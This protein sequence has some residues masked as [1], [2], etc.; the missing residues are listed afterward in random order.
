MR[1]NIVE[2]EEI[3]I[4]GIEVDLDFDWDEFFEAPDPILSEI[5]HVMKHNVYYFFSSGEKYIFG[6]RVSSIANIP[7]TFIA[8]KIP[9]GLYSKVPRILSTYEHDM[10]SMTNYEVLEG[11]EYSEYRE[12]VFGA[13]SKY[14]EYV[15]RS[16]EYLPDVVNVRQIPVLPEARAKLLRRQYIETFFDV[17]SNQIRKFLYKRY[18][19]LHRGFL[20]E[21]LGKEA[22]CKMQGMSLAEATDFLKSKQEVLFFWDATSKLGKEFAYGKV[23]TMDAA[24]LMQSYTR[25]TFDMYLFDSTMDWTIIFVH[26]RISDKPGDCFLINRN[27]IETMS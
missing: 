13:A 18:V 17:D 14:H 20:W 25:F 22:C 9:A 5:E 24:K 23:F 1:L 8:A 19:T 2:M 12:F 4:A 11:D 6:K 7:E 15:Y 16:V 10:F 21:F 27:E 26:E 3:Y